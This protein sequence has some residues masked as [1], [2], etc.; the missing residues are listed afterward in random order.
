VE[1]RIGDED[2]EDVVKAK[3]IEWTRKANESS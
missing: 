3:A 2:G 1:K